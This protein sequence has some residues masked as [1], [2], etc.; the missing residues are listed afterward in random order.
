MNAVNNIAHAKRQ[1]ARAKNEHQQ[2]HNGLHFH[3]ILVILYHL[4]GSLVFQLDSKCHCN[5]GGNVGGNVFINTNFATGQL[6]FIVL[7]LHSANIEE[8]LRF[9]ICL[10]KL[11]P[12]T[13]L[14]N[15]SNDICFFLYRLHNSSDFSFWRVTEHPSTV[16]SFLAH[17]D[18]LLENFPCSQ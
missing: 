10:N 7:P 3:G 13:A 17:F 11:Y 18:T 14:K 1:T 16:I 15:R 5:G 2:I 12:I 8:L 6:A 9:A 4:K